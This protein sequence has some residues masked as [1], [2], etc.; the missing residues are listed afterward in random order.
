MP[1]RYVMRTVVRWEPAAIGT[2][3]AAYKVL[4]CGHRVV[5]HWGWTNNLIIPDVSKARCYECAKV[6]AK[7]GER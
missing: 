2:R 4:D 1:G 5:V 7:E 3:T 6:K